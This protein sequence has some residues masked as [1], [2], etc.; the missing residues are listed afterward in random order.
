MDCYN[1]LLLWN[2]LSQRFPSCSDIWNPPKGDMNIANP[3]ICNHTPQNVYQHL[4]RHS[5][6]FDMYKPIYACM[7]PSNITKSRMKPII[8][9]HYK[10]IFATTTRKGHSSKKPWHPADF[11]ESLRMLQ[12]QGWRRPRPNSVRCWSL[13]AGVNIFAET[14]QKIIAASRQMGKNIPKI[15]RFGV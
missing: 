3:E 8:W 6:G 13:G 12:A 1:V 7:S 4:T 5:Q 9:S 2:H 15:P 11:P 10:T 14:F